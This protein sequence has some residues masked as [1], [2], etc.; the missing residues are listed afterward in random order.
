MDQP[1]DKTRGE[2]DVPHQT[3]PA[4]ESQTIYDRIRGILNDA[5]KQTWQ[6]ADS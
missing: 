6:A 5:R 4:M 3:M 1:T 2:I